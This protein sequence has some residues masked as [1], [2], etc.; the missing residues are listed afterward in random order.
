[1]VSDVIDLYDGW[2][3]FTE[4]TRKHTS[5]PGRRCNEDYLV[6]IENSALYAEL[7]VRQFRVINELG[8]D[9]SAAIK[10]RISDGSD[11][12]P[13][14]TCREYISKEKGSSLILKK[15]EENL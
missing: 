11:L 13:T 5:E 6:S 14:V 10:C 12:F 8:V 15:D 4:F 3:S 7:N 9:S 1:M 2:V